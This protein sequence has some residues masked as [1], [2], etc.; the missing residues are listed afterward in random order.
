M[1]L[2]TLV[3]IALTLLLL[4]KGPVARARLWHAAI[5][6]LASIIGSGFLVLGPI[7]GIGYGMFAPLIMATLC[8][9]AYLFGAAIRHNIMLQSGDGEQMSGLEKQLDDLASWALAFAYVISVT[10]YLN[11]FGAFAARTIPGGLNHNAEIITSAM[12]ALILIIGWSRGFKALERLELL[13]VTIKL[14]VIAGLLAALTLY[15]LENLSARSLMTPQ[16]TLTGWQGITI[17]LGLIVTVQ[18]FETSRYL[19]SEYD[20]PTRIK[21][22]KLAQIIAAIIYMIY[23]SLISFNF[24]FHEINPNDET[25]IITM[26]GKVALVLPGA[27]IIAALSAQLSAAIADTAGSGGLIN[28]MSRGRIQ[29]KTA[30]A[31]LVIIGLALTWSADIFDIIAYASRAFALYYGLQSAI[32]SSSAMR[33]KKGWAQ[34]M[35]YLALCL[36]SLIIMIFS[37]SFEGGTH[38]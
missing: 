5:T 28:E 9:M 17:A 25:A 31:L 32:A 10:Y 2:L 34:T 13:S 22:M 36:A 8:L 24:S 11:L 18:G 19:G 12:F 7:L 29:E 33:L 21:S 27:L 37:S 35:L 30:Y 38:N 16:P 4:L 26:M 15:F 1:E 3:T 23:I 14:A 6:P 20:R